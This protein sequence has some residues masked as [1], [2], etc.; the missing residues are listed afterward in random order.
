MIFAYKIYTA[1]K[2]NNGLKMG[3]FPTDKTII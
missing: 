2:G 3:F 1:I